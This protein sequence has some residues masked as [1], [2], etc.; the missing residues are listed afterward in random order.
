VF[1]CAF[2]HDLS[3]GLAAFGTDIDQIVRLSQNI[4]MVFNDHDT[5][6]GID[7]AMHQIEKSAHIGQMKSNGRFLQ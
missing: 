2:D 3:S 1:G 7:Q 6:T 4:E 5:V